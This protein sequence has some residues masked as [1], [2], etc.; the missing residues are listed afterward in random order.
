MK[1]ILLRSF[2]VLY[3]FCTVKFI[4]FPQIWFSDFDIQFGKSLKM[5][6]SNVDAYLV[7]V[8]SLILLSF[9]KLSYLLLTQFIVTD[10]PIDA[11]FNVT[12]F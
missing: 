2:Y 3:N 9:I 10:L 7:W 4:N 11:E 1:Y 8:S 6:E 12:Q 5:T